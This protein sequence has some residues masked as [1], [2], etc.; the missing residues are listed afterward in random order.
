MTSLVERGAAKLVLIAHDVEPVELV[1]WLPEL[2]RRKDVPFMIVKGKAR[3]GKMVHKKTATC[4]ALV[5]V[6]ESDKA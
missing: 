2:C 5:N 6:N 1:L 3:L 4:V